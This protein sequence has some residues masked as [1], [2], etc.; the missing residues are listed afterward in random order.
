[1]QNSKNKSEKNV[2]YTKAQ[3]TKKNY[4][5]LTKIAESMNIELNDDMDKA[6][7]I[8]AIV[9]IAPDTSVNSR[10][11]MVIDED[12][13]IF[14]AP[15]PRKLRPISKEE[16]EAILAK[17]NSEAIVVPTRTVNKH[18]EKAAVKRVSNTLKSTIKV[19]AL[20]ELVDEVKA[21]IEGGKNVFMKRTKDKIKVVDACIVE[22]EGEKSFIQV[23]DENGKQHGYYAQYLRSFVSIAE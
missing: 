12:E 19:P 8:D 18:E 9:G 23:T 20:N 22:K 16:K 3:L 4:D 10:K 17:N 21:A 1:M 5:K 15:A 2:V 13:T 11:T 6:T 7:L 14:I